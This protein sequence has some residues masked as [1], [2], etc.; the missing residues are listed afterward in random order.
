MVTGFVWDER[1]VW[2]DSV[3]IAATYPPEALFEPFPSFESPETKRRIKNLLEVSGLL[4]R[5]VPIAA[6]PATEAEVLRV[7][8]AAYI[9]RLKAAESQVYGEVGPRTRVGPGTYRIA[10][11]AAGG[12]IEAVDAV[13]D[14]KVRNV[15][16]LIRPPGHHAE[17][18]VGMGFCYLCNGAI[19]GMH[20]LEKRGLKRIA[21]VDW[22][23][24]HGNGTQQ[25]FWRDPRALTISL[26]QERLFPVDTGDVEDIGE[27]DGAGFNINI[28]L[29]AGS[30]HGAYLH[31]F[32]R[33]VL[34]ALRRFKPELLFIS[35][36]FDAGNHDPL[37]RMMLHPG[38]FREMTA[39]MM[40]IA[41]EFCGGKLVM[42]HEGGYAP[43]SVPYLALA[44]IERMSSANAG[45][46]DPFEPAWSKVPGQALHAHQER[47]VQA[48]VDR[49]TALGRL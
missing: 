25:A 13:L 26:H 47:A 28:P 31:A 49:F 15:Y 44:T 46:A 45:V 30:G 42:T 20:A 33:V 8:D 27:G 10:L 4:A 32:D 9:E 2:H 38:S 3:N 37:G 35:S 36:G 34:P 7:H 14:G 22:D 12:A 16:A 21:Y 24:H 17:R 11:L 23:V 18:A 6:R 43:V 41:D 39:R 40:A 1:F 5:L 19:A 29:P 48:V